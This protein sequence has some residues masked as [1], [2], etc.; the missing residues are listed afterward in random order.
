MSAFQDP[1]LE[2]LI[3]ELGQRLGYEVDGHDVVLRGACPDCV[4]SS[5]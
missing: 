5:A 3:D 2:R 4:P 1:T